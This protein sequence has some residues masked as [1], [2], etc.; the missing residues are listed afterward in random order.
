MSVTRAEVV[1]AC[2]LFNVTLRPLST[3]PGK[4]PGS[5][6]PFFAVRGWTRE[7][8]C[9]PKFLTTCPSYDALVFTLGHECGHIV[10]NHFE[11]PSYMGRSWE[12]E[13][14]A[15]AWGVEACKAL[16][17]DPTHGV[18]FLTYIR[19]MYHDPGFS[20]ARELDARIATLTVALAKA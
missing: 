4:H 2:S 14:Q 17:C 18:A 9:N 7:V 3:F 10:H 16:G 5:H 11:R 6:S 12:H 19:S 13:I 1:R 8:W 20:G 15:D